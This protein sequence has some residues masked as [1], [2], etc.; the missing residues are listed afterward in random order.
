MRLQPQV[1]LVG[2][3]FLGIA[4]AVRLHK[5]RL[6]LPAIKF[7]PKGTSYS[8]RKMAKHNNTLLQGLLLFTSLLALLTLS[9]PAIAA[10]ETQPK[11]DVWEY[12]VENNSLL[13]A[14]TI[15]LAVYPFL[16]PDK[17]INDIE[18]AR[19]ALEQ[20]YRD[21]GYPTVLVDIPEQEVN[22]GVVRLHAT[23]GR[24]ERLKVS[25]AKYFSLSRMKAMVPALA[26]GNVPRLA[27]MQAQLA[28]LNRASPDRFVTPVLRPGKTPG[29]MEMELR[30]IDKLP[31]HAGVEVNNQHSSSTS[32]LRVSTSLRYDNLWQREHSLSLQFQTAPEEPEQVQV[33]SGTYL[34]GLPYSDNLVAMYGVHSSSS[35]ATLGS[36][37]VI[38]KG[39]IIGVRDILPL[40][41]SENFYH[42][43]S[44]GADYKDFAQDISTG[45]AS[46]LV[47]TPLSYL[48]F[49]VQ[50]NATAKDAGGNTQFGMGI[51]FGIRGLADDRIDCE[52][53]DGN[54]NII[55]EKANEFECNRFGT[56][57]NY[58]YFRPSLVRNQRLPLGA[59]LN[60]TFEGQFS[61]SLLVS[62]E[63]F[64]AG[65]ASSVRG[66]GQ[67]QFLG[68]YGARTSLELYSPS[69]APRAAQKFWMQNFRLLAFADAAAIF[70]REPLP[71]QDYRE[72]LASVGAGLRTT[73]LK[74]MGADLDI[75]YPLRDSGTVK[76]GDWRVHF[77]LEFGF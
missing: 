48:G 29:T 76:A 43:L 59:S 62:N 69:L 23:E 9:S 47:T 21:V 75:A 33:F 66:Y 70:V 60:A 30:V 53:R 41:S 24:I 13:E 68:D 54:G 3:V 14:Q 1:R 40:T 65:G 28:R 16:G 42:S 26:E 63:Q 72:G 50:Y 18:A 61:Q 64:S 31:L 52:I 20:T 46:V 45:D 67:S 58:I 36:L 39:D 57:A 44:I 49:T 25:G 74:K 56:A 32:P 12:R 38:G 17:T 10:Q 22:E 34:F 35:V 2:H 15:E 55:I 8:I 73:A 11:F 5:Q 77:R 27:E 6:S 4:T 7:V 19:R 37:T 51:N 71:G